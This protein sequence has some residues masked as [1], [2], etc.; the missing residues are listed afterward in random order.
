MRLALVLVL[1]ATPSLAQERGTAAHG[2]ASLLSQSF[3]CSGKTCT[4][5]SS[6]AEACFNLHQC[7]ARRRDGDGDGIPCENLCSRRC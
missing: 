2:Q 6:C 5:M 3:S 1:L 4:Q 7:G